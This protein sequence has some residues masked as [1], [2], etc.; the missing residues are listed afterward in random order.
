VLNRAWVGWD[1]NRFS[2]VELLQRPELCMVTSEGLCKRCNF[3]PRSMQNGDEKQWQH[4]CSV[5]MLLLL[6]LLHQTCNDT[7]GLSTMPFLHAQEH[8]RYLCLLVLLSSHVH[9]CVVQESILRLPKYD[10]GP[11]LLLQHGRNLYP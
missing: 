1:G 8:H 2:R 6:I 4:R 9:S 10:L 7:L 11:P 3:N 5:Q